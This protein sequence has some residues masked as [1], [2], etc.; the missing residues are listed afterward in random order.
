MISTSI[1]GGKAVNA[2][3]T[4][5]IHVTNIAD[6]YWGLERKT[7]KTY[8]YKKEMKFTIDL[9][10]I[11]TMRILQIQWK[12]RENRQKSINEINDNRNYC[13]WNCTI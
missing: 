4:D 5:T 10:R 1:I 6:Y 13:C 12:G 2:N 9:S 7:N 11:T 8:T 3:L